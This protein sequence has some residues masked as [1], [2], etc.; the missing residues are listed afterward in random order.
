MKKT[1]YTIVI[2]L[3]AIPTMTAQSLKRAHNL[4][5]KKAYVEAAEMYMDLEEKTP[6]V[7]GNLGDCFYYNNN[8]S[9]AAKWY[10][11]FFKEQAL[12]NL[13]DYSIIYRYAMALKGLKEYDDADAQLKSYYE[14][15]GLDVSSLMSTKDFIKELDKENRRPY[16]IHPLTVNSEYSDFG[17]TQ[18]GNQAVFASSRGDGMTYDWNNQAYLNL[19]GGIIDDK[20]NISYA[21]PFSEEINTKMH[22]SNAVFTKDGNTMYFT[23]N[24]FSDGKKI[25]DSEKVT[26]LKIYKA[27][28][29]ENN[30]VNIVA[31][32][33]CS[34]DFSVVH[35]SLSADEKQL[36]FASDMPGT[37]GSFDLRTWCGD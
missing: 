21:E 14:L 9:T 4:F 30:W 26:N 33:F 34:D 31:L 13:T 32:P 20:G 24:S 16:V 5:N 35:P 2:L 6:E 27:Q 3:V 18:K 22:E 37:L 25:K 10:G 36:Y 11:L 12:E 29:L 15:T 1:I 7:I 17:V 8:M 19:Y 28:L 23:R